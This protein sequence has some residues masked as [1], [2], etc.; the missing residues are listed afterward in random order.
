M[1]PALR[2]RW[3]SVSDFAEIFGKPAR[4]VRRHC[5]LGRLPASKRDGGAWFID[6]AKIKARTETGGDVL[7]ADAVLRDVAKAHGMSV[8]DRT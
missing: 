1:H 2:E 7:Y 6:Y 8:S 4:T 5:R 3:M